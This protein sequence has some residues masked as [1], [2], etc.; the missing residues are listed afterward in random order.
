LEEKAL[1]EGGVV[2]ES[3]GEGEAG[4]MVGVFGDDVLVSQF[5]DAQTAQLS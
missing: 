1:R 3:G 4:D 2:Y 5:C